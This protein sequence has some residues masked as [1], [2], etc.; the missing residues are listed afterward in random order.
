M[1]INAGYLTPPAYAA[2]IGSKPDTVIGWIRSGEL[3]AI[4]VASRGATRPR[5]RISPEAIA[6]FERRR[7]VGPLPQPIHS[8]RTPSAI[9]SFV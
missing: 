9:K 3:L 7:S 2:R 4:N 5:Y 1:R 6:E 8:R